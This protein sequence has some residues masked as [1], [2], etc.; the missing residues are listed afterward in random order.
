M[1]T[2][3]IFEIKK[4]LYRE[5]ICISSFYSIISKPAPRVKNLPLLIKFLSWSSWE[6]AR[7]LPE[8]KGIG[9]DEGMCQQ[10]SLNLS[11]SFIQHSRSDSLGLLSKKKH[12]V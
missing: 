5:K 10:S 12:N 6:S 9:V 8:G 4:K 2:A 1:F 3:K 11:A 7:L